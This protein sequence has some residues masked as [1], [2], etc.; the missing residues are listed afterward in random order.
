MSR[1]AGVVGIALV[2]AI[3]GCGGGGG[4]PATSTQT[5]RD[6]HV[7]EAR[8]A[9]SDYATALDAFAQRLRQA[10]HDDDRLAEAAADPPQLTSVDSSDPAYVK[11]RATA[12]AV[13]TT[14]RELRLVAAQ[15]SHHAAN[16][17]LRQYDIG[18][19]HWQEA[20]DNDNRR[21]DQLADILYAEDGGFADTSHRDDLKVQRIWRTG[22]R[23]EIASFKR[24]RS[25]MNRLKTRNALERSYLA[26]AL[27]EYDRSIA[28][29]KE[30]GTQLEQPPGRD[31][32]GYYTSLA[33]SQNGYHDVANAANRHQSGLER[34]FVRTVRRLAAGQQAAPGDAYRTAILSGFVSPLKKDKKKTRPGIVD[35]RGWM[36]FRIRQ[37]EQT[38]QEAYDAARATLQLENI[39]DSRNPYTGALEVYEQE[40]LASDP[41]GN[42]LPLMAAYRRWAHMKL[43]QPFPPMLQPMVDRMDALI[44]QYPSRAN[45]D[46][47]V[48]LDKQVE[49]ALRKGAKAADDPKQLKAALKDALAATRQA[50][51]AT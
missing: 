34:G 50:P 43:T 40:D 17:S 9:A 7:R 22:V 33:A 36:L 47:V 24:A 6:A 37:I 16:L 10:G 35:E 15:S 31:Q 13:T 8:A 23:Q 3:A 28:V 1:W 5:T 46:K 20:F 38:P 21:Y 2:L 14:A 41:K 32:I 18:A 11:A 48:K 45:W 25:R 4:G 19:D 42:R 12:K 30:F 49:Q 27:D 51:P 39:D 26:Y 29:L 44:A